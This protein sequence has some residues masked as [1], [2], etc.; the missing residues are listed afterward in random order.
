M[1]KSLF[2][3]YI[4]D[5]L[6]RRRSA[7]SLLF[8]L[9]I[10]ALI[11]LPI[12]AI[13]GIISFKFFIIIMGLIFM[14]VII[15]YL[16]FSFIEDY[17]FFKKYEYSKTQIPEAFKKIKPNVDFETYQFLRQIDERIKSL[18]QYT[19]IRLSIYAFFLSFLITVA[20]AF[21]LQAF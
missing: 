9:Y 14:I 4:K 8:P 1:N 21:I 2:K 16:I 5:V 7:I 15:A 12:L 19:P 20:V 17:R 3:A 18:E 13:T 6:F 10:I 11:M